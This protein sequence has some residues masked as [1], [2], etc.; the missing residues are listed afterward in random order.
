MTPAGTKDGEYH[1]SGR[2][3]EQT[4]EVLVEPGVNEEGSEQMK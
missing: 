3:G 1:E 4:D 2:A